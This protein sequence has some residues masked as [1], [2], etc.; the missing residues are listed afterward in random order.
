VSLFRFSSH[1]VLIFQSFRY[2][3]NEDVLQWTCLVTSNV[4]RDKELTEVLFKH[5]VCEALVN[6]MA[7]H[8]KNSDLMEETLNVVA[9]IATSSNEAKVIFIDQTVAEYLVKILNEFESNESLVELTL[10]AFSAIV[11]IHQEIIDFP[12]Q[13][14]LLCSHSFHADE[15]A[16]HQ[17]VLSKKFKSFLDD[18]L[19]VSG[20]KTIYS[21]VQKH[22]INNPVIADYGA[23]CLC[24]LAL[25]SLLYVDPADILASDRVLSVLRSGLVVGQSAQRGPLSQ[26]GDAGFAALLVNI[27]SVHFQEIG[28]AKWCLFALLQLC[29]IEKN[30]ETVKQTDICHVI[31]K[32]LNYFTFTAPER[33]DHVFTLSF[34]LIVQLCIF[35]DCRRLFGNYFIS[36]SATHLLLTALAHNLHSVDILRAGSEA[37]S[38]LCI[39]P[40]EDALATIYKQQDVLERRKSLKTRSSSISAAA[41]LVSSGDATSNGNTNGTEG[42]TGLDWMKFESQSTQ[43]VA[44]PG[45]NGISKTGD[46]QSEH[47]NERTRGLFGFTSFF[48]PRAETNPSTSTTDDQSR[49]SGTE[50][51]D[52]RSI[53][54]STIDSYN[55]L[56]NTLNSKHN[57]LA[58]A[59]SSFVSTGLSDQEEIQIAQKKQSNVI[60]KTSGEILVE[61]GVVALLVSAI[62]AH[63]KDERVLCA[64]LNALNSLA[65]SPKNREKFND[66]LIFEVL[67]EELRYFVSMEPTE[68]DDNS[69]PS[70]SAPTSPGMVTTSPRRSSVKPATTHLEANRAVRILLLIV[71]GTV[72]MPITD[73]ETFQKAKSSQKK[74]ISL[75]AKGSA[76]AMSQHYIALKIHEQNQE[77][78]ASLNL[79]PLFLDILQ[80]YSLD[81]L[82]SEALLRAIY[83]SVNGNGNNQTRFAKLKLLDDVEKESGNASSATRNQNK[84]T[85]SIPK[86]DSEDEAHPPAF[87]LP[88]SQVSKEI[89]VSDSLL[90]LVEIL[91]QNLD[92]PRVIYYACLAIS[93]ICNNNPENSFQFGLLNICELINRILTSFMENQTEIIQCCC[94]V[95]F[96]LKSLNHLWGKYNTC[97]LILMALTVHPNNAVVAEWVCRSIGTLAENDSNK[98]ELEKYG[99]SKTI[100]SA[101]QKHVSSDSLLSLSFSSFLKDNSSEGVARWGCTAIYFLAKGFE[102]EHFQQTLVQAGA[103]EAVA[104]ALV[105]YSE[106]ETVAYCCSRALVVLLIHNDSYKNKLGSLGVCGCIVESLH[107]FPSSAQ[108]AKWGSRAVAVL[109]ESNEANIGKLGELICQ[110][111]HVSFLIIIFLFFLSR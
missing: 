64:T 46:E 4:A 103:C 28:I 79:F 78:F 70:S 16:V 73:E 13:D 42:Q 109:A 26:M 31:C 51:R 61:F 108:V 52:K 47:G 96:N 22:F 66:P 36:F 76:A 82:M 100:V 110:L 19:N 90:L 7:K 71:I 93:S 55:S 35:A 87:A 25:V 29:S 75:S 77:S 68:N 27:L 10:L 38:A 44:G 14:P 39:S 1:F 91:R 30:L 11:S 74:N 60:T 49:K 80:N 94:Q 32:V 95:I 5:R 62:Q 6:I 88:N 98:M 85:G 40:L 2:L 54:M 69:E 43:P 83:Y 37:I 107:L 34:E 57:L 99:A 81:S 18:F 20:M 17:L 53:T 104:K 23:Q 15:K 92:K 9:V 111:I 12:S 106:V 24:G 65:V 63:S 41:A 59:A 3:E 50:G 86:A 45:V 21:V 56:P 97:E 8:Y 89:V 48:R 101:I 105:K 72:C 102:A 67:V 58:D 84:A 33:D